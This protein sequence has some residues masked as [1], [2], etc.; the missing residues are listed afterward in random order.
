MMFTGRKYLFEK[1][2]VICLNRKFGK[3]Q[4]IIIG[5]KKSCKGIK[6]LI[7]IILDFNDFSNYS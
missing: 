5:I 7:I 1:Y 6:L 2:F 4:A 3:D